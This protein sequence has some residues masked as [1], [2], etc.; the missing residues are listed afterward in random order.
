[1]QV[2]LRHV[3]YGMPGTREDFE[4]EKFYRVQRYCLILI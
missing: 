2:K 1:M 3:I 4:G